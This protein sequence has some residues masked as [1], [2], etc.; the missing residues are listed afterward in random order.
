M[1]RPIDALLPHQPPAIL[2]DGLR[3]ITEDGCLA[4]F[5]VPE[6]SRYLDGS[7]RLPAWMGLE[8]MAQAASAFSGHRN[9]LAGRPV[10]VGYLLGAR[11]FSV[12]EPAF[13][14]GTEL[15]IDVRVIFLDEDGPSAFRCELRRSGERVASATLKAIEAP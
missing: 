3:E 4:T 13:P 15:E 14:V 6:G 11:Q 9:L 10:R 7:G 5:R 1:I 8:M 2:L 12:T